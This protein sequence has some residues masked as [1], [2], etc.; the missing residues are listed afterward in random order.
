MTES[1]RSKRIKEVRELLVGFG[2]EGNED[3]L[4]QQAKHLV[5]LVDG[6]VPGSGVKKALNATERRALEKLIDNDFSALK[7]EV[8]QMAMDVKADREAAIKEQY[9][10]RGADVA[11]AVEETKQLEAK[12]RTELRSLRDRWEAQGIVLDRDYYGR[13]S[14]GELALNDGYSHTGLK[15][16]IAQMYRE[17]ERDQH[18][19]MTIAE[20]QR[21]QTQRKVLLASITSDEALQLVE[22]IPSAHALLMQAQEEVQKELAR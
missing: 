7:A 6:G 5:D 15:E 13:H 16:A 9:A 18:R 4:T 21:V 17:V 14:G 2:V 20:R 3:S 1:K 8:G 10:S 19:A 22:E 11:A 12:F